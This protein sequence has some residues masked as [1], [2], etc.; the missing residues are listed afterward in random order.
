[1]G[2]DRRPPRVSRAFMEERQRLCNATRNVP[3]LALFQASTATFCASFATRG[4]LLKQ[5]TACLLDV[6]VLDI[7][8]LV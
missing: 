8:L 7:S 4:E 1:M 3:R 2:P 5:S 6:T